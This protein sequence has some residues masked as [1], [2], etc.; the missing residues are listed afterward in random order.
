MSEKRFSR[1]VKQT[2]GVPPSVRIDQD[3]L[4]APYAYYSGFFGQQ[5]IEPHPQFNQT[6]SEDVLQGK[7]N[8]FIIQE[9]TKSD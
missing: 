2:A 1:K 3:Q 6:P 4:I 8:Q 5:C 7:N 9:I